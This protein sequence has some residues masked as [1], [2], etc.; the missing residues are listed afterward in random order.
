MIEIDAS[1]GEGGG[2]IVRTS[3]ALAMCTGT[4][5]TLRNIRAHRDNPGL[6]AQHL[7]A[8]H[9]AAAICSARVE[10]DSTA[11]RAL[12]FRPGAVRA[13]RYEIDVGT[14]GARW[15]FQTIHAVICSD[16]GDRIARR[17]QTSR[18]NV[19]VRPMTA[20]LLDRLAS[21]PL[22]HERL[23]SAGIVRAIIEPFRNAALG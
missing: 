18:A 22:T 13:G 20:P 12:S 16:T 11:S 10:G 14:A 4:P 6:R 17:A 1:I 19:R 23:P 15:A 5:T 3:L 2:Q 21:G 9:G 8:V 7:A